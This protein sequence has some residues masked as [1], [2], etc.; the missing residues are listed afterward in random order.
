MPRTLM[1]AA[2]TITTVDE[3]DFLFP[4]AR[5]GFPLPIDRKTELSDGGAFW[6][7]A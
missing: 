3:T 4:L 1:M 5:F 6:K 2:D 7:V